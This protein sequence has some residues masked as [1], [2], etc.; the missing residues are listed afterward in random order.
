MSIGTNIKTLRDERNLTQEQ[1]AEM[2]GVTFQAVSSWE[3]DEYK[4]DT[5]NLISLA[6]ALDVSV[7]SILEDKPGTFKMKDAIYNWEHMKTYIKTTARN[8]KLRNTL[9]AVDFATEA[10]RGVNRKRSSVPFIYHPYNLACHALAMDIKDDAVIA[11]CLLHDVIEDCEGIKLE[12]LPVDEETREIVRLMTCGDTTDENR[13]EILDAYYSA[14]A[15]NPKA[16][17]VKCL[18]RCHNLST[19]AGGLSRDRIYRMMKE[20][21][22]YYPDLLKV[23]KNTIEYNN[24]SWLLQYQ[25]ESMLDIYKRLM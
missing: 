8:L 25:I 18:D 17:L 20:T 11:A 9:S 21:E 14:L 13:K 4:P 1:L 7:A 23:L 24:A 15:E 19:M 2:V 16:A 6:D 3:R 22:H 12:D 10:H 5:D